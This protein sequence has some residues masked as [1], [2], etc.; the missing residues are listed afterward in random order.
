MALLEPIGIGDQVAAIGRSLNH[1][2]CVIV[3]LVPSGAAFPL[4]AVA[5]LELVAAHLAAA[6]R[7]RAR[8][9]HDSLEATGTDAVLSSTGKLLH[10]EPGAQHRD[11]RLELA[12][13]AKAMD[14]ARGRLRRSDP[15]A[16][17]ELWR[18][19][20]EG[21]WSLLDHVDRDG[22]RVLLARR[23]PSGVPQLSALSVVE[24]QVAGYAALGQSNKYIAYELGISPSTVTK[25]LHRALSMLGLRSR[26]EL[27]RLFQGALP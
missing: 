25:H 23:N 27:I 1:S 7:L 12:A 16:A 15:Q 9:G 11:Q 10:A 26:A 20:V 5:K 22:K 17:L 8:G 19:L 14:R 24:Q 13:A 3:G 21:R 2:G 4:R 18:A 6:R